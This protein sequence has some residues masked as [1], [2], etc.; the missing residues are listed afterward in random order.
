MHDYMYQPDICTYNTRNRN[1]TVIA[2]LGVGRVI[3]LFHHVFK[4]QITELVQE[5]KEL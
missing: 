4:S 2:V 5:E 1:C 3:A